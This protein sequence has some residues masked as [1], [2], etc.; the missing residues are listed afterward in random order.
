MR[1][2]LTLAAVRI[3]ITLRNKTFL[4]FSL[5]M[6]LA[7]FFLYGSV[8]ARGKPE[9]VAY[10]MGPILSFTV[11]GTFWGLSIQLVTWREQGILRRFRLAPIA[12]S[13]MIVSSIL[14]NYLLIVPTVL[15]ELFLARFIYHVTSFGNLI[16]VFVLVIL[17]ITAFGAMGLVVASVTNTMQETQIINQLLWFA[18]IFLSGATVPLAVLP[19]MVQ[20]IGLFLPATYFVYGLQRAMLA[21]AQLYTLGTVVFS[22]IA[23]AALAAFISSQ[24]FRWEPEA[25]LPR[26]AKLW[27]VA[28]ILPFVLLGIWENHNGKLLATAAYMMEGRPTEN[29]PPAGETLIPPNW[30]QC[31]ERA[32]QNGCEFSFAT[33]AFSLTLP[34]PWHILNLRTAETHSAREANHAGT[35][36][37]QNLAQRKMDQLGRREDSR[38]FPRSQLWLRRL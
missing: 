18:L 5:I 9:A 32:R 28:T 24:L 1:T 36:D 26:N 35:K 25:K 8:F 31:K 3:R 37:R 20:R 4:F 15:L 10:L 17:G 23:W 22:L 14:A 33:R 34:H 6:P 11:M 19:H 13:S 27:A 30:P 21:D 29:T 12:A 7:I 16:S 2:I 38:P